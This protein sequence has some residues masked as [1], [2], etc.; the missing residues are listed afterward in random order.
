MLRRI[1]LGLILAGAA[2][3]GHLLVAD[4]PGGRCA[5]F[6]CRL[7]AEPRQRHHNVQCRW[8]FLLPRC[9][10]PA[11]SAEAGRR[12]CHAVAV[13]DVLRSQH[14]IRSDITVLA[15][16]A[17]RISS[18]RCSR[19]RRRMAQHYFPAFPYASYQHATVEDIR[20]LFAYLKTLRAGDGQDARPRRP[21]SI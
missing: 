18:R 11:R 4:H 15:G 7:H 17:K 16:G 6:A 13:R 21:V 8:L 19:G 9:S 3:V 1:L 2:G 12:A 5:G 20:D 14:L 10:Q